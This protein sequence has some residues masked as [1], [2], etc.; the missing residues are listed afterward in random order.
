VNKPWGRL[1]LAISPSKKN[2]Q[3]MN[4]RKWDNGWIFDNRN[5]KKLG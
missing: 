4:S 1:K 5:P 3:W 2:A